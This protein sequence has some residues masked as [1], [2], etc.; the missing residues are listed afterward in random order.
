MNK[1]IAEI[2]YINGHLRYGHYELNL[3]NEE[4]EEFKNSSK[5]E[6]QHWIK[7]EGDLIIDDYYL[8]DI[9]EITK[10]TKIIYE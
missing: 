7:D 3:T 2:Y 1:I 5:E 10:I 4:L 6:Q 9:G 8:N